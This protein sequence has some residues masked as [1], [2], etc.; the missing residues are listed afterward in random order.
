MRTSVIIPCHNAAA[1]LDEAIGSVL[2]QDRPADEII[3]IDDASSDSS[4]AVARKWE[5][6]RPRLIRVF[7]ADLRHPGR[8]RN[9]G[10]ELASGD[11]LLFLDADDVLGEDALR[12]LLAT[13]ERN[14]EAVAIGPW[15]R[16]ERHD[17]QWLVRPPSCKPRAAGEDPLSAWLTGWYHPPCSVLW[18]RTAFDRAGR[19]DDAAPINQ[20]G[21]L[22]M[23]ALVN[24]TVLA[25]APHG[26]SYYRRLPDGA[27]SVSGSRLTATGLRGR[28]YVV[29]KIAWLLVAHGRLSACRTA[30]QSA[31][32]SIA[33]DA[34]ARHPAIQDEAKQLAHEFCGPR[35]RRPVQRHEERTT[36]QLPAVLKHTT[37][38]LLLPA[39]PSVSVVIPT[40]NRARSLLSTLKTVLAQSFSDF[41]VI[42]VDD[43][44]TDNTAQVIASVPDTRVRYLRQPVNQGAAAAR[45]RGMR[46]ARGEF[47]AFLDSDDEWFPEKLARQVARFRTAPPSV[48]LL[49][50]GVETVHDDGARSVQKATVRGYAY[51]KMLCRNVIHGGGSNVMIRRSVVAVAGFFNE[52]L[53][54]I[55]DY[56]YWLRISRF[57]EI[58]CDENPLVRYYDRHAGG[59]R[60][61]LLQANLDA[62][63][64]FYRTYRTQMRAAG[65]AH[66]FLLQTVRW[67]ELYGGAGRGA[68]RRFALQAVWERPASRMAFATL[69]R[70]LWPHVEALPWVRRHA[71]V[72]QT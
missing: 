35:W 43:G 69:A 23:R 5:A 24:G 37:A 38:A 65:A 2:A 68:L 61:R 66:L 20:D 64:W 8:I 3:V 19:W 51:A 67:A 49:Y 53:P 6:L 46:E 16:L 55:E 32:G 44:S 21:D 27:G 50:T 28:L 40:Y 58:D 26:M 72:N 25:E 31:F 57:F 63:W 1:Y 18:S 70:S 42:V 4:L 7:E 33:R 11:A 52:T 9:I 22:V 15:R 56:E 10:A 60:S 39:R 48:G 45:N 41:E 47:V 29:T 12:A 34:G 14:R 36:Q 13:V 17:G 54:A 71:V 30:L 59:R 62:R